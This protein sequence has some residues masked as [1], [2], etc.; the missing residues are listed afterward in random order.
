MDADT[1]RGGQRSDPFGELGVKGRIRVRIIDGRAVEIDA[2][3]LVFAVPGQEHIA[4]HPG[5]VDG[6][7]A[8]DAVEVGIEQ[9]GVI[10]QFRKI[11]PG[12][13]HPEVL[14]ERPAGVDRVALREALGVQL[15]QQPKAGQDLG[16]GRVGRV[17]FDAVHR[18]ALP[19]LGHQVGYL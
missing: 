18:G 9:A 13:E 6:Q 5:T 1:V 11:L 14:I 19:G 10:V 8:V 15:A 4:Q 3:A 16:G 7:N 17:D 2:H 12:R